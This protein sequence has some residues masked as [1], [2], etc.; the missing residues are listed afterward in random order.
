MTAPQVGFVGLG[1][2]GAAMAMHLA[3]WPGGL[4]VHDVRADSHAPFVDRGARAA[5]SVAELAA[6]C[7]FVSVM[8]R[9]DDQVRSVVDEVLATAR[10]GA[11]V[12]VHST[13]RPH[14]AVDVAERAR[15]TG[16]DLL[17][18]PV[19]GGTVGAATGRLAVMVG[20]DRSAYERCRDVLRCWAEVVMHLGPVGAG[21]RAKLARNLVGFVGYCAAAEAQRLAEAA[22]IDLRK[23]GAIVRH[24]DAVTGGSGAIMLRETTAPLAGDDPLYDVLTHARELG[25]KDLALALEVGADLH[26][27]LPF[28]RL[29]LDRLAAGLGLVPEEVA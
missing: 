3:D 29:A 6:D 22:G 11:V 14:T 15:R 27:D 19:S 24:T 18:A 26:V 2:M 8:V 17:D 13:I 25:E 5:T 16:V 7:D 4:V 21:T 10:A 20:G 23:L 9:D 12:A 28:T 1:Q